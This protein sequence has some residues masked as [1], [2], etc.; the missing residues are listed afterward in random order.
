M[1]VRVNPGAN[2]GAPAQGGNATFVPGQAAKVLQELGLVKPGMSAL[3]VTQN[4]LGALRAGGFPTMGG[5]L[6]QQLSAALSA[7]QRANGLP[8]TGQLDQAT[9]ALLQKH[10]LLPTNLGASGGVLNVKDGFEGKRAQTDGNAASA[11][12]KPD[13]NLQQLLSNVVKAAVDGS[14]KAM[15]FLAGMFGLG[16]GGVAAGGQGGEAGHG[17]AAAQGGAVVADASNSAARTVDGSASGKGS[18]GQGRHDGSGLAR[19]VAGQQSKKSAN[20]KVRSKAGLKDALARGVDDDE[21]GEQ[22]LE[23]GEGEGASQGDGEGGGAEDGA[24][25]T[26]TRDGD[27]DGSERWQGN[28]SSGDSD[29]DDERRGHATLD[30]YWDAARGHYAIPSVAEQWRRA[31]DQVRKDSDA[32]NRTT[33]Y[34][35]DVRFYKP[36]VYGAGQK[37]QEILHLVVQE[38][39]AFDRAWARSVDALSALVKVHDGDD[40]DT[41]VKEDMLRAIR[42]ARVA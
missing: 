18:D 24:F 2:Q 4:L 28:A 17:N 36:G 40:V 42:R 8:V 27:E 32:T 29:K 16:G 25:T 33:T 20:E 6:A 3:Q 12:S 19:D 23:D 11:A 41:P 1:A 22:G 21:D 35:W 14:Q 9:A 10:G 13:A 31:L 37:G 15:E 30:D 7:F 34:T 5:A 26:G 39:T 38:A